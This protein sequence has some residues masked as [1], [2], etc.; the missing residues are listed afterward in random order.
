MA[1]FESAYL[2]TSKYEGGYANNPNDHGLETFAGISRKYWPNWPGWSNIDAIKNKVGTNA[3][4]INKA[5]SLDDN[6]HGKILEFYKVN[7]WYPIHGNDISD[8]QIANSV[9]DFSV[10]AGV[11][12]SSRYL[13]QAINA[14]CGGITVDG[15]IGD[16]T[17][18]A[19]N[20]LS[21]KGVY[22]AFNRL[23]K[24]HYDRIIAGNPSQ[25]QFYA[26]WMSRIKEYK[27]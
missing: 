2:I 1:N 10:N 27:V 6:L 18:A 22:D 26:S 17:I 14:I 19:L 21:P 3:A 7:F 8:Q 12:T 23:R 11:G 15:A 9:F 25:K 16:K 4:A 13:Q 24:A 20:K 5:A